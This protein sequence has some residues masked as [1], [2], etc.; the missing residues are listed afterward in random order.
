MNLPDYVTNAIDQGVSKRTSKPLSEH[1][2]KTYKSNLKTLFTKFGGKDFDA[3][4]QDVQGTSKLISDNQNI[5]TRF[6]QL[7]AIN[8]L[9]GRVP[10]YQTPQYATA[11]ADWAKIQRQVGDLYEQGREQNRLTP[12]QEKKFVDISD[13]RNTFR[14]HYERFKSERDH[15]ASNGS[16]WKLFVKRLLILSLYTLHPP[17]RQDYG[18]IRL[19]KSNKK[20]NNN[21]ILLPSGTLVLTTYKTAHTYGRV[22]SKLPD[23]VMDILSTSLNIDPR[24]WLFAKSANRPYSH[25]YKDTNAFSALVNRSLSEMAGKQ[26][27]VTTVRRAYAT[28]LADQKM[29]F[30]ERRKVAEI[31]GHSVVQSLKYQVVQGGGGIET[32][33]EIVAFDDMTAQEASAIM[34]A[35]D[36]HR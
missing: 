19:Y 16:E 6:A 31:M 27:D 32:D 14:T 35:A 7:N 5:H 18:C 4:I 2:K 1:S 11:A 20:F 22:E 15:P 12:S 9:F 30:A 26:I 10:R 17:V 21:H 23:K 8:M 3:M 33:G 28:W 25:T 36:K 34:I 13:L 24:N 29:T